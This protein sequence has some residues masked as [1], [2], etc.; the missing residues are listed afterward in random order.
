MVRDGY[1]FNPRLNR[2]GL[3]QVLEANVFEFLN[4]LNT[5]KAE[6]LDANDIREYQMKKK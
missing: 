6:Q 2:D 3:R 4:I 5:I 1:F